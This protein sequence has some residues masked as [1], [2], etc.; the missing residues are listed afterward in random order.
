MIFGMNELQQKKYATHLPQNRI[1]FKSPLQSSQQIA[2]KGLYKSPQAKM[3]KRSIF[4][5]NTAKIRM[6]KSHQHYLQPN[7]RKLLT[8]L[9]MRTLEF[10]QSI[11]H[12][13]PKVKCNPF[14]NSKSNCKRIN[15]WQIHRLVIMRLNEPSLVNLI[16]IESRAVVLLKWQ[17]GLTQN[18]NT[19]KR[20]YKVMKNQFKRSN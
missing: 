14:R 11:L 9:L 12:R 16:K 20:N 6:I 4:L 3:H 1:I 15:K 13:S 5:P 18:L 10:K 19:W 17:Q 2:L 8:L 7:K